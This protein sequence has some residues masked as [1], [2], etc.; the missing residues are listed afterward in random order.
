MVQVSLPQQCANVWAL[1]LFFW[2]LWLT[3]S[4]RQLICSQLSQSQVFWC[5][6]HVVSSCEDS[7]PI[8]QIKLHVWAALA[9]SNFKMHIS[10]VYKSL[11]EVR[12]KPKPCL[13]N[14]ASVFSGSMQRLNDTDW[15]AHLL[16][17]FTID[18]HQGRVYRSLLSSCVRCAVVQSSGVRGSV[19]AQLESVWVLFL[20]ARHH[21]PQLWFSGFWGFS[22]PSS[23]LFL[24]SDWLLSSSVPQSVLFYHH[25]DAVMVFICFVFLFTLTFYTLF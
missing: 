2:C 23:A 21:H 3:G 4:A 16:S 25:S 8:S 6:C 15:R 24:W 11:I 20:C 14:R 13:W 22:S 10:N 5:R 7:C 19:A 12:P 1:V 9:E 18:E 17:D